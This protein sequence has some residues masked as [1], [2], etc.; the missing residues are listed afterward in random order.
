MFQIPYLNRWLRGR[1]QFSMAVW[2]KQAGE[3]CSCVELLNNGDWSLCDFDS[4]GN[5]FINA[6][7]VN[8]IANYFLNN[9]TAEP[10]YTVRTF[11]TII[12][13]SI[14]T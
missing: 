9:G 5:F 10:C 11:V 8:I 14:K 4:E 12:R 6:G 3:N 2:F 13:R 1:S 7:D